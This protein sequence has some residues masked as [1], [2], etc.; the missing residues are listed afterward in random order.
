LTLRQ[1][2]SG[3]YRCSDAALLQGGPVSALLRRSVVDRAE[4][5]RR[6]AG[7]GAEFIMSRSRLMIKGA[8]W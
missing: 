6:A 7:R 5:V 4:L 8:W 3:V 1:S 2:F